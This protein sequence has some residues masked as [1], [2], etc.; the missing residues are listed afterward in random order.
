MAVPS[1]ESGGDLHKRAD[2]QNRAAERSYPLVHASYAYMDGD[3]QGYLIGAV[4]L[5]RFRDLC[6]L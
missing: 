3:K 1:L 4:L 2:D 6:F 5:P